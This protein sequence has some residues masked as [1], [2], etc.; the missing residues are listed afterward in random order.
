VRYETHGAGTDGVLLGECFV[1]CFVGE[2]HVN[3][4]MVANGM[5][6]VDPAQGDA[7][8]GDQRQAKA[9]GRAASSLLGTGAA[10]NAWAARHRR[11][12]ANKLF[13]LNAELS[14]VAGRGAFKYG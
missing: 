9:C 3:S 4:L 2:Q 14:P 13:Q 8:D 12:N 1:S 6:M 10:A 5:A 7:Y 11:P